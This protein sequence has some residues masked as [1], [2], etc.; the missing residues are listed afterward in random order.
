MNPTPFQDWVNGVPPL[1]WLRLLAMDVGG[2]TP[3]ALEWGA[4]CPET[5][6]LVIYDEV[7]VTTTDMRAVAALSLPKMKH[8]GT[9]TE[10]TFLAKVGDYENRIALDDMSKH[11][12]RF[13]NAVKQNKTLSVHRLAAYLHPNP[14]R[15]FPSWHPR[16]GELGAPLLFITPNCKHAIAEL[17]QQKWKAESDGTTMKDELDRSVRHDAVDCLLYITRIL[18]APT[19]IPIPKVLLVEDL[20]DNNSKMYWADV[21][22]HLAQRDQSAPRK[23]YNPNHGGGNDQWKSL[24]GFSLSS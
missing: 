14:L 22:K 4:Q 21:K 19:Q 18:P 7:N 16:A 3:N 20:R 24:L 11:G 6:S 2:A 13:T 8:P 10:Y 9:E 15:P 23:P 17:P 12:I 5:Q 1:A